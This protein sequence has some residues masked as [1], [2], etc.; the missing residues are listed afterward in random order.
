MVMKRLLLSCT[1]LLIFAGLNVRKAEAQF[2]LKFTSF[3]DGIQVDDVRC[4]VVIAQWYH[5]D[6]ANN[7]PMSYGTWGPSKQI[8]WSPAPVGWPY[9]DMCPHPPARISPTSSPRVANTGQGVCAIPESGPFPFP[10][11]CVD[12]CGCPDDWWQALIAC[13]NCGGFGDWHFVIDD[14]DNWG[15]GTLDMMAGAYP[16]GMCWIDEL[17]YN[18]QMGPCTTP[19]QH[20]EGPSQM[21]E[22]STIQ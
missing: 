14:F 2:C 6:C 3:C 1:L 20:G 10:G 13:N 21:Q 8:S 19:Q 11:E 17:D 22:R 18:I 7:V 5:F 9:V 16:S 4:G 12:C 15:D